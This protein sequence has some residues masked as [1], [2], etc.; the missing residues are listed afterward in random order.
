MALNHEVCGEPNQKE[1]S[2]CS[3][4]GFFSSDWS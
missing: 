4:H 2:Y 3:P 1:M